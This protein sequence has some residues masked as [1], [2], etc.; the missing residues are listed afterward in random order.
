M[1]PERSGSAVVPGASSR[2]RREITPPFELGFHGDRYLLE[3]VGAVLPQ[4]DNFVETGAN[5]GTTAR[6]VAT[7][8]PRINVYSCEPDAEAFAAARQNLAGCANAVVSLEA[9]PDFLYQIHND[10]P[11]LRTGTNL[12]WLDAHGYGFR[13]PLRDEVTYIT[14]RQSRGIFVIDDFEVPGRPEFAFE[15]AA[16]QRCGFGLIRESLAAGRTYRLIYPAYT[17]HTSPHHPLVGYVAV[18]FGM[19]VA[20]DAAKAEGNF[21]I[22]T[23][24]S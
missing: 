2:S 14:E 6:Y 18:E 23:F 12:Y 1:A 7:A 24:E 17:E 20:A 8:C 3:L 19:S 21:D 9:S 22:V 15:V 13:W 4:V 10:H 5:V 11:E 16:G